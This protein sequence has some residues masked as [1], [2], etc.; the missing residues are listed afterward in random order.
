MQLV[1]TMEYLPSCFLLFRDSGN[2]AT[3]EEIQMEIFF[4]K[5]RIACVRLH[6]EQREQVQKLQYFTQKR[7]T[8]VDLILAT[9]TALR[10]TKCT[11]TH[12]RTRTHAVHTY[13]QPVNSAYAQIFGHQY[14]RSECKSDQNCWNLIFT[15]STGYLCVNF[16]REQ[17]L[18]RKIC[19]VTKYVTV[20]DRKSIPSRPFF[21][22]SMAIRY[23]STAT[24]I[25]TPSH[26]NQSYAVTVKLE[27][28]G[29]S[30]QTR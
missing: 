14:F 21:L 5:F 11:R 18:G 17:V 9:R 1:S 22:Y 3:A 6:K 16:V 30:V 20:I 7:L 2:W 25:D 28:Q 29:F 4:A 15:Q 24:H 23:L 13:V 26:T 27:Q 19:K 12:A 10:N 8:W